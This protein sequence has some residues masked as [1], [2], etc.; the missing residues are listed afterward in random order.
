MLRA[1]V[2]GIMGAPYKNWLAVGRQIENCS[3]S[4]L[5]YDEKSKTYHVERFMNFA[6]LKMMTDYF[7]N[8]GSGF[9]KKK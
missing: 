1:L 5:L 9:F 8:F 6:H 4:Q 2:T 7:V 3:I